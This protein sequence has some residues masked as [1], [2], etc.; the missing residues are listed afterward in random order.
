MSEKAHRY[1]VHVRWTGHRGVGTTSYAS[2]GREH[3]VSPGETRGA[4]DPQGPGA[5]PIPGSADPAF[6]GVADRWNPE[7]LLVASLSQCHMLWYLHLAAAAGIV[8]TDYTDRAEGVMVEEASGAGRFESVTLH[9]HVTI[10]PGGDADA[11]RR[12]HAQV[13]GFCFI[14]R[15]VNFPVRHEPTIDIGIGIDTAGIDTAGLDPSDVGDRR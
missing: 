13:P 14:T 2:Y 1:G 11:A 9:P 6:R 3:V 12:L 8:V 4:D 5:P 10:A 7:Q 15:S